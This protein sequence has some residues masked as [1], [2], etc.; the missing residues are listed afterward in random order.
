MFR[1]P[2]NERMEQAVTKMARQITVAQM[3]VRAMA[4]LALGALGKTGVATAGPPN[5]IIILA[6]DLGWGDLGCYGNARFKTPNID[7]LAKSG[8]RLTNFYAPCPYCAPTRAAL[9]TGRYPFR[10][11]MTG[12]PT[13]D[14]GINDLGMPASEIT[15]GEAFQKAGYQTS[16]VG[17]WHLGH[18][19]HFRP[20][21]HGYQEYLGIL[22]S[23]DMH[24]VELFEAD[25]M[26]EY[27]VY[28]PA[29]TKRYTER[30]REFIAKSRQRPFFLMLAHAMPHKPLAAS[31]AFY[32]STGA[33]LYADVMA[34][35]D[36]SVGKVVEQLEHLGLADNTLLVFTSDN[37]PWYG[38]STGGLRG[39]KGQTWE[40]GLR[41]PLIARWPGRIPAG[42]TSQAPAIM[43]DLFVTALKAAGIDPPTDRVLDGKDIM[44]LLTSD[45]N[46]PHQALLGVRGAE[47][48]SIRMGDWKLH[49]RPP[50]PAR[51]KLMRPDEPW[52]D[53]RAPDGVRIIAPFEQYHPSA[54]PGITTGDPAAPIMLFNLA[55][56]PGEQR[57]VAEQHPQI[58]QKLREEFE[59]L[60]TQAPT[61]TRR[62]SPAEKKTAT[63]KKA[64]IGG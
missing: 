8:A 55:T 25:R 64:R 1:C 58:V 38:G 11:G 17:K 24:P 21:L 12:N 52:T 43:M 3:A 10:C 26:I 39:M 31:E 45:A 46:S 33:G 15:L 62:G 48:C 13:P 59:R 7:R 41:V 44:P 16:Y 29:L 28:Q 49:V 61:P 50:G 19:P 63:K 37:G 35:L 5:V 57:N 14:R 60:A 34:E 42:H 9:Q 53:P 23:N 40:G 20:L 22:Y 30:A 4:I 27:P 56:D 54:H 32:K 18:R 2:W 36:W 47:P 6:D 51:D